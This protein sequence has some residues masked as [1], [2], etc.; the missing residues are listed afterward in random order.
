MIPEP[1]RSRMYRDLIDTRDGRGV[2][3]VARGPANPHDVAVVHRGADRDRVSVRMAAVAPGT[4]PVRPRSRH[5]VI[6][7]SSGVSVNVPGIGVRRAAGWTF[8]FRSS[9]PGPGD[10]QD[11]DSDALGDSA[12]DPDRR[13]RGVRR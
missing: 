9:L 1:G 8:A 5:N 2:A 10:V 13:G 12:I 3:Q 6:S 11:D 4:R 7:V